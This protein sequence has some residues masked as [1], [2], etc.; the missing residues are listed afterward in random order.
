MATQIEQHIMK[1]ETFSQRQWKSMLSQKPVQSTM[2]TQDYSIVQLTK[3][4]ST[5]TLTFLRK[6]F[7]RDEPLNIAVKLLGE[8]GKD[9]CPELDSFCLKS[10]EEPYSLAAVSPS[11]EL[12]GVCLNGVHEPG[13]MDQI[14]ANADACPNSKFRKI[15]KLLATVEKRADLFNRFPDVDKLMEVRVLSVDGAH[16]GRG[17]ATALL[18]KTREMAEENSL[19]M[20]RADCTSKFSARAMIRLGAHCAFE[21]PYVTYCDESGKPIFT[22]DSP[23]IAV[24][25]YILRLP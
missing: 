9:M 14:E 8:D 3:A 11:G 21:M 24:G 2:S 1:T 6:F 16:R 4:D 12:I 17:I 15:L 23:H 25:T 18:N 7:F 22:P 5:K 13:H 10:L 19:K 20:L